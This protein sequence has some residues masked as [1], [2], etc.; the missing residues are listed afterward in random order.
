M[1]D[2]LGVVF[3]FPWLLILFPHLSRAK[4]PRRQL[5]FFLLLMITT[6][7][8]L[9]SVAIASFEQKKQVEQFNRNAD[10][11]SQSMQAEVDAAIDILYSL[12][13]FVVSHPGLTPR[14]F[15]QY[16]K[17]ILEREAGLQGLS[18][19]AVVGGEQLSDFS[20]TMSH[21]YQEEGIAYRVTQRNRAGELVDVEPRT[22]HVVVTFIEPLQS[23][24]QALGYD[25]YSQAARK[26]ALDRAYSLR[27][28][29][30][31]R[32][33]RLLQEKASQA[34][35][36]IFLPVFSD[37]SDQLMGYATAVLRVGDMAKRALS[38]DLLLGTGLVLFD[39]AADS[40]KQV[41]FALG[42]DPEELATIKTD[43]LL[44]ESVYPLQRNNMIDVGV[45]QWALVQNSTSPFISE[46]WSV[47]ILIVF[48]LIISALFN[49][50][51]IIV[52]GQ[53]YETE[54]QVIARTG[55]LSNL[56]VLF[57][58][59]QTMGS[60]GHWEWDINHEKLWWSE[61]VFHILEQDSTHFIPSIDSL[62]AAIHP[63]DRDFVSRAVDGVLYRNEPFAVEHRLVLDNHSEKTVY[64]EGFVTF[65]AQN[66][67]VSMFGIIQD[68]T[69]R[70][71]AEKALEVER[72]RLEEIIWATNV[73]T[74]EWDII[75]NSIIINERWADILGYELN[76]L[77]PL[78]RL[79]WKMLIH[80]E[81]QPLFEHLL[82]EAFSHIKDHY[83]CEYRMRHQQGHWVWVL[84][85]GKVIEWTADG[86]PKRMSGTQTDITD[87]K[88][89]D[90]EVRRLAMTDVLTGLVNRAYYSRRL[91][92]TINI[93][94]R[95]KVPFALL[96][97]DLDGFK[98]IND[99]YGHPVGDLV[100]KDFAD[101]LRHTCR[102][103][104]VIARIGGDEFIVIMTSLEQAKG[105]ELLAERLLQQNDA[106]RV[107]DGHQLKIGVSIG[108]GMYTSFTASEEALV[109]ATDKALYAAKSAGKNNYK[110]LSV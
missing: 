108:V 68:I 45:D 99:G 55:E 74:W 48:G 86:K 100:L 70:K 84:T 23:N 79:T 42:I 3:T 8:V 16:T 104:D 11:L 64:E 66:R 96:M 106:L 59:A 81:D 17:P 31:T 37:E 109:K 76:D 52:Y 29:V 57:N 87:R 50:F 71:N 39:P 24:R 33:I 105:A 35:V 78:S 82:E 73:G 77:L 20:Q 27:S 80:Q 103:A 98:E 12:R 14:R 62:L 60:I 13:G 83:E 4:L 97:L 89:R 101:L 21:L 61:E 75:G 5:L 34:G 69:R 102:D 38:N 54:Q 41:L 47:H 51:I 58:R 85:R 49:W 53:S 110:V 26:H 93:A 90:E 15:Q 36:L 40:D 46:S 92:E 19:N 2:S 65:D 10:L 94:K 18:W 67:P 91:S 44:L 88:H 25:V 56:N 63:D 1:G 6:V 30:A 72:Q 107:I 9:F 95:N 43:A 22:K 7:V 32:P 28:E